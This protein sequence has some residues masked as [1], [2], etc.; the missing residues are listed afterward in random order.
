MTTAT[1][2]TL[3]SL[4]RGELSAVETYQQ[5][6]AKLGGT[7]GAAELQRLQLEHRR[8]ANLLRDHVQHHGGQPHRTS[9]MWGT[10]AK[11]VEGTAKVFG[12]GAALKA[13]KEGEEHGIKQYEA[14][15]KDATLPRESETLITA[16]LLPQT[17]EHIPVLDGLMAGLVERID[18]AEARQHVQSGRALL[19]CSYDDVAKVEQ[20]RLEGAMSLREFRAR[21]ASLPRDKEIIFYCA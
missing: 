6:I 16:T 5:A 13:L 1:T 2:N 11:L 12:A 8:A 15:V 21:A 3:N 18:P 17:R 7:T 14:V 19:V 20:H 4:L 9:G 10:F